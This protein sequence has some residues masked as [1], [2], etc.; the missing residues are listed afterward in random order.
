MPGAER[1][2]GP[3]QMP[4]PAE[5]DSYD[6]QV[7]DIAKGGG[8]ELSASLIGYLIG[9]IS[10]P[11][12]ARLLGTAG[13]GLY[14]LGRSLLELLSS[15]LRLGYPQAIMRFA[16]VFDG[17]GRFEKT[18]GVL[19]GTLFSALALGC[20]VGAA[21]V[22]WPEW[23]SVDI[24][25]KPEFTPVLRIVALAL[26]PTLIFM[27][28]SEAT[29][30]RRDV[31]YKAISR[32][33]IR[34]VILILIVL[35]V[36]VLK[37][38]V[39]GAAYAMLLG[40]VVAAAIV[41]YG[42]TRLF[43]R[44]SF[45]D[46]KHYEFVAVHRFALPLA[47]GQVAQFGLFRVNQMI[48]GAFVSA[49]ALGLFG[50]ASR[51]AIFGTM[52]LAA[53]TAIFSPI[54]SRLHSQGRLDDLRALFQTVTRWSYH[55]TVPLMVFA[56]FK[57]RSVM[58]VFGPEFT[59]GTLTLQILCAGEIVNV[60]V[61]AASVMLAMSGNQWLVAGNN[62]ALSLLNI[63]LCF[64]LAPRYGVLG[65]ALSAAIATALVNLVRA[66]ELWWLYR[67]SAYTRRAAGMPL[68]A[69]LCA[70]PLLLIRFDFWALDI[71]LPGLAFALAYAAVVRLIGLERDDRQVLAALRRK[72][73]LHRRTGPDANSDEEH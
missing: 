46:F 8:L 64:T 38:G 9:A 7:R 70:S 48:G 49:A 5:G 65:L 68:L 43:Q 31:R 36:G 47:L 44:I 45:A 10:G 12:T 30:A 19:T 6:R 66:G 16:G 55:F 22:I 37:L 53:T 52:G 62:V 4:H 50:A 42:S 14:D 61:G 33:V 32:I 2:E 35:L 13:L 29:V 20:A 28:L 23:L 58:H 17:Q 15:F 26:P 69:G 59:E 56:I 57:A 34:L 41:L 11:V 18:R 1:R 54:I 25:H 51:V 24:Y 3:D 71:L 39:A 60:S 21:L 40:G 73:S 72:L 63:G 67:I 27:F